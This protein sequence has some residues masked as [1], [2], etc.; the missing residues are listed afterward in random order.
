MSQEAIEIHY[1]CLHKISQQDTHISQGVGDAWLGSLGVSVTVTQSQAPVHDVD[2]T[3]ESEGG[4]RPWLNL[5]SQKEF[6]HIWFQWVSHWVRANSGLSCRNQPWLTLIR[7]QIVYGSASFRAT[8]TKETF[9]REITNIKAL[10]HAKKKYRKRVG[11]SYSTVQ[12][13]TTTINV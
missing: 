6:T 12:K 11:S 7:R 13:C 5:W 1:E 3:Q 8:S 9:T 10:Q 2:T 4:G